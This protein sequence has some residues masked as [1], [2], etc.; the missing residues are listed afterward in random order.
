M[1]GE[2]PPRLYIVGNASQAEHPDYQRI[3]GAAERNKSLIR[4]FESSGSEV[5]KSIG[6]GLAEDVDRV[7]NSKRARKE[8]DGHTDMILDCPT[9]ALAGIVITGPT[10][11]ALNRT[12]TYSHESLR[13]L[14]RSFLERL[15]REAQRFRGKRL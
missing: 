13:D 7:L 14:G 3:L 1:A 9:E 11:V 5:D 12:L 10:M 4:V 8:W 2:A 15:G 6:Q